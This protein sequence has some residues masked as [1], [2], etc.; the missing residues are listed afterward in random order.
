MKIDKSIE[1]D[2]ARLRWL[3]NGNGYFMEESTLCGSPP[4]D[5]EEQDD[6]RGA[7]DIEMAWKELDAKMS[8]Q[9]TENTSNQQ[10]AGNE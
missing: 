10:E 7:I 4:C 6:A 1:A 3:L 9:L 2:A 5:E 8:E